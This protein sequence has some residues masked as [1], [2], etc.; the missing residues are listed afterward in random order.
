[1]DMVQAMSD[2]VWT[3][4]T[5]KLGDLKPW[6]DNPRMS[7]KAQAKRLLASF[8]KF[9]Q[10]QTVAVDPQLSVLDGHQRLSAL[11][12]IHGAEYAIDARQSSRPLSEQERK[13]LVISLHAGAVGGWDWDKVS[14]W[15]AGDLK[16]WGMDGDLLKSW[17]NDTN[18]LKE[19]LKSE[20][21]T[22]DAEVDTDRAAELL[23]K[24]G[25]VT[26]DLWQIGEHRLICGDCTDAAVVARVMDEEK[27]DMVF[28]SP[29]YNQGNEW[30]ELLTGKKGNHMM[31]PESENK[32]D[33]TDDE[34]T[35]FIFT[36][37]NR[38]SEIVNNVHSVVWNVAYNAKSRN[39]YGKIV[40][41]DRNPFQV[42]ES[43]V[44]NK[45]GS[46]NL[47]HVGIYSRWCEFVYVMAKSEKYL[48]SQEYGHPRWNYWET[49]KVN[50]LE[51]HKATFA[52]EFAERG[53]S[54][55][56]TSNSVVYEPFCGSGTVI[57]A[58]QNLSR[59]C[60]AVEISPVYVA[61]ALERMSQAFPALEI[62]RL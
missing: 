58:C 6:S 46:I 12:T 7:S 43:I 40:F 9:G 30:G 45:G 25:V 57:V 50:Q 1:V 3:N 8:D 31:Y 11:L 15:D 14:A 17:N 52:L 48:T 44:W 32:D 26:G 37:L 5:V 21:P 22:T 24:W 29:P 27:A 20:Q 10:V 18:N 36:V 4:V 55:L 49:K 60:R 42:F 41:S 33:M 62:K 19:L 28:T 54:E 2:L 35:D 56:S 47:P 16:G 34:Y 39:L 13:E 51:E 53:V 23:E 38:C 59:R 61:V